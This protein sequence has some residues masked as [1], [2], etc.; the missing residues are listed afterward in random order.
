MLIPLPVD[1]VLPEVIAALRRCG[2]VVLRAPTGAGKTTR[3]PPAL[4]DA[5]L[6]GDRLI[7]VLEPRRLAAQT[8]ARRIASERNERAGDTC[9]YHIRFDRRAGPATRILVV[10]EGILLRMLLD[11]PLLEDIGILVFDEFHERTLNS[12][13][14]LAIA[15]RLQKELRS[16]LKLVVMSATLESQ[17][18]AD[19]LECPIVA[20]EGR[21]FPVEVRYLPF[22]AKTSISQ[23]A[24]AGVI[25]VLEW[26]SG[27]VLVFLPG[28]A[29]IRR[30][31]DE[32]S[33][34]LRDHPFAVHE[35][36][37]ELPMDQ[38]E[39]VLRP[40]DRRK[41]ILSTNVAE[42]SVTIEGITAVVDTGLARQLHCDESIGV[43]RLEVLRIS[44]ASADQR[45]GRAGRT[46]PG[47][48]LRLWTEADHRFLRERESP[49][50]LRLELSGPM[51]TLLAWGESDLEHFPWFQSPRE[52]AW[53]QA[54]VLLHRLGATR[55][56]K[57]TA[58]GRA[59][60]SVPIH[61]R[62]ARLLTE[63]LRLGCADRAACAASLLAERDP[64]NRDERRS[65]VHVSSSDLLDRVQAV[66]DFE[67]TGNLHSSVGQL[68]ASAAKHVLH[69]KRQLLRTVREA[70]TVGS[71]V[72]HEDEE[73]FLRAVLAAFPDRVA[74]RR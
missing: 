56:Q 37:G 43:N 64:F 34:A 62:L 53:H 4:L 31:R 6:A 59:L 29:E 65:A 73:S 41:V 50:I 1:D 18:I 25:S 33:R 24:A 48:C 74:R 11:D 3:V 61:P 23:R 27:D 58:S 72:A 70:E 21:I 47:Y 42:T 60:A 26:T 66:E 45:A 32:L 46:A 30:T 35:L 9:G 63:G 49:E 28:I 17:P 8:A 44:R 71:Q 19:F 38:Q 16:D 5:G 15:R 2:N 36:Y 51:L 67:A 40:A 52:A 39:A 14:A 22:P 12:D 54:G 55:Q 69:V 68:S 7:V 13:L 10:T 57:L 20:S